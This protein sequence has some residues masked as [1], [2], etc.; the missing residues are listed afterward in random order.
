MRVP[1]FRSMP[2]PTCSFEKTFGLWTWSTRY[3]PVAMHSLPVR[4]SIMHL[5]VSYHTGSNTSQPP[6]FACQDIPAGSSQVLIVSTSIAAA[7]S[8][9]ICRFSART[10]QAIFRLGI[11]TKLFSYH[12]E[13]QS[14]YTLVFLI[15]QRVIQT[16]KYENWHTGRRTL[17]TAG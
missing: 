6:K 1:K 8:F 11:L 2:E 12:R 17:Q 14:C 9:A 5:P 16:G 4:C 7:I 3:P 15:R 10:G 13:N